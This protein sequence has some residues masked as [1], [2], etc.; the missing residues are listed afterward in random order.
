MAILPGVKIPEIYHTETCLLFKHFVWK[1]DFNTLALA[2]ICEVISI[3]T[4][5]YQL[6]R[7]LLRTVTRMLSINL[8]S[9]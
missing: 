5:C 4:E 7:N 8:E 2:Q 3:E 9:R 1:Y 6:C